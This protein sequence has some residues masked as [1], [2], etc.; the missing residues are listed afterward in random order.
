MVRT[1]AKISV[2]VIDDESLKQLFRLIDVD[3]TG[4]IDYTEF[5]HYLTNDMLALA[6]GMDANIITCAALVIS[7]R[8]IV[9]DLRGRISRPP[10][11]ITAASYSVVSACCSALKRTISRLKEMGSNT[12]ITKNLKNFVKK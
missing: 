11:A 4:T 1:A 3:A 10:P 8:F 6:D 9:C 2:G 7:A 5:Q 12:Y